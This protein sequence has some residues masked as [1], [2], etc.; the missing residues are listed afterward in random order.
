M[1]PSMALITRM[2]SPSGCT[3]RQNTVLEGVQRTNACSQRSASG[4]PEAELHLLEVAAAAGEPFKEAQ[5]ADL[6]VGLIQDPGRKAGARKLALD[7]RPDLSEFV[8]MDVSRAKAGDRR[9]KPDGDRPGA[10]L[11]D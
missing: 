4:G 3:H 10:A 9:G 5:E 1:N 6:R 11:P 8:E 7:R 2:L